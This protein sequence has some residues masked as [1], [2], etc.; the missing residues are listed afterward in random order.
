M[1]KTLLD[2]EF[3]DDLFCCLSER[4][5][6]PSPEMSYE[7]IEI[8]GRDGSLTIEKG[9]QDITFDCQY[10]VLE[11]Y[12]VKALMRRIK[13]FFLGKKT[14]RLSDDTV[15]YKI[16][17]MV[18]SE[19]DNEEEQYGAFTVTFTCDPFQYDLESDFDLST[20]GNLRNPGSYFSQPYLKVYGSGTLTVNGKAFVIRDVADFIELDCETWNAYKGGQDMNH[21]VLGDYP[22][23]APGDNQVSFSGSI[24]RITG[25]GRWRHV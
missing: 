8:P 22:V 17:R 2:G 21:H 7:V 12:N 20:S 15:L 16:K 14:L 25:E 11:L 23:F 6:I 10:N 18:I 9:Y 13:A 3:P 5:V 1:L 4:P 24:R 19:I